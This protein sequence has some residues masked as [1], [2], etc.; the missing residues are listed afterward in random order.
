MTDKITE[1]SFV[2]PP[3]QIEK[4]I[5]LIV[6]GNTEAKVISELSKEFPGCAAVQ[7]S[8]L[9]AKKVIEAGQIPAEFIHGFAV[10]ALMETHRMALESGQ[11]AESIRAVKLLHDLAGK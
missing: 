8:A 5:V 7:L 9:A 10:L 4:A 6:A 11:L 1:R 3:E 2:P